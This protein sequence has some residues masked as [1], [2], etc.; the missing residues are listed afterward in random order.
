MTH[1][2]QPNSCMQFFTGSEHAHRT[3]QKPNKYS[4]WVLSQTWW[5]PAVGRMKACLQ[6]L[7]FCSRK[8][9]NCLMIKQ[10]EKSTQNL[11]RTK[12]WSPEATEDETHSEQEKK[13]VQVPYVV[14]NIAHQGRR[15]GRGKGT[16]SGQGSAPRRGMGR[17]CAEGPSGQ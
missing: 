14:P 4:I 17:G 11:T 16:T 8:S 9:T 12:P 15:K 6:Q 2:G 5:S 10:N 3:S 13:P 7:M 1:L